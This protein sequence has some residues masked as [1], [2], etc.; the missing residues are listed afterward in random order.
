MAL[1]EVH[2]NGKAIMSTEYAECIY[3]LRVLLS[4][5]ACGYTF[6]YNGKRYVPKRGDAE[7]YQPA[8]KRGRVKA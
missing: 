1:F 3:P 8:Q 6:R 4:M 2:Q 5:K 7:L